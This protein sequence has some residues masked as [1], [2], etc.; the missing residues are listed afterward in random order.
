LF[1]LTLAALVTLG[2]PPGG[3]VDTEPPPRDGVFVHISHGTEH[4]HRVL[5]GL[6]M[7][8]LMSDDR[9]VAVYLDIDA[10]QIA[11][12]DAPDLEMDPF[13]SSRTQLAALT[14]KGVPV[15][16]CPGCL[17]AAGKTADDLAEGIRVADKE[18]FFR[19]TNGRI[20]TIDY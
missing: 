20:L 4:A 10:I 17:Q 9:D 14:E 5:M 11:L 19:F 15:M 2:C 3:E 7:A 8:R 13:P 6:Q 18:T 1:L 12:K 16:A